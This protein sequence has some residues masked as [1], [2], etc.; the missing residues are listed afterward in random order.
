M[1]IWGAG[2]EIKVK[3]CE[4]FPELIA[5]TQLIVREEFFVNAKELDVETLERIRS[6]VVEHGMS[7]PNFG[8]AVP[9]TWRDLHI[10]LDKLRAAGTKILPYEEIR[11]INKNLESPLGDEE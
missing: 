6:A 1:E 10:E 9:Q 5:N 2:T 8:E 11:R 3:I 4:T 7:Y